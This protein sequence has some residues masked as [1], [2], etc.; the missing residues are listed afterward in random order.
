MK[1]KMTI[2]SFEQKCKELA[3]MMNMSKKILYLFPIPQGGI[4]VAMQLQK[5]LIALGHKDVLL[6]DEDWFTANCVSQKSVLWI[7]DD[8]IDSGRTMQKHCPGGIFQTVALH[9]KEG[10]S[11]LPTYYGEKIGPQTWIE[12]WWEKKGTD[13]K[14]HLVRQ[15]EYIGEDPNR[16]GLLETPKRIVKSWDKIYGGYKVDISQLFKT[17][18]DGACDSMVILKNIEFFSTCE[19][20][21]LPFHGKANI[22]YIPNGKVLGISKLARLL[23]AF[24]RRMQIQERIGEQVTESLMQYLDP[25]GAICVLE[26]QHFCM[27]AR[28]VEKQNSVMVTSSIKG[29]FLEYETRTEFLN[30][31]K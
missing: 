30:L 7:V 11:F 8:I 29:C 19:H 16:E 15:I 17:F 26:A 5:E 13:I 24:S 18:S 6:V 27:T 25:L 22:A 1:E 12:Y 31:I 14:D 4:P 28:G 10:S 21:L 20:H 9:L 2:E 3:Q 23:E